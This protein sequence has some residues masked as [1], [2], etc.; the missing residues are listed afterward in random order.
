MRLSLLPLILLLTSCED[1]NSNSADKIKYDN[2]PQAEQSGGDPN[3]AGAFSVIKSR[4]VNC[5]SGYHNSWASYTTNE[6]WLASGLVNR[7]DPDNSR[8]IRRIINSGS[9]GANMPLGQ[10][11]LPDSEYQLLRKWITE[12]P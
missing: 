10:G 12:I 1:Y 3:F 7:G 5:H 8:L 11:R 2:T 4:C 6:D 9:P